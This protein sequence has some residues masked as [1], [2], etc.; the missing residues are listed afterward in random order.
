MEAVNNMNSGFG[1]DIIYSTASLLILAADK[2]LS[3]KQV[4]SGRPLLLGR[5]TKD[6]HPDVEIESKICGR[7]H[8]QLSCVNG[9]WVY[10]DLGSINGTYINGVLYKSEA[11]QAPAQVTLN[12]G[13][14]IRIDTTDLAHPDVDNGVWILFTID[15][16]R[17]GWF[18]KELK[19]NEEVTIGRVSDNVI[20]LNSAFITRHH[21]KVAWNG[22]EYILQ[23][24]GSRAGTWYNGTELTGPVALKN[25]DTFCICDRTFVFL[26]NKL[27]F[28]NYESAAS[29]PA[30]PAPVIGAQGQTDFDGT[31][32]ITGHAVQAAQAAQAAVQPTPAAAPVVQPTPAAAPVAQLQAAVQPTPAAAPVV[33][34][35]VAVQPTPAVVPVPT[36]V[37][38]PQPTPVAI[39]N[40]QPAVAPA[41]VQTAQPTTPVALHTA[42]TPNPQP[43]RPAAQ[44]QAVQ[45]QNT[46]AQPNPQ[47]VAQQPRQA[48]PVQQ[49]QPQQAGYPVQQAGYPVQQA[50]YPV[51]QAGYPVQQAGYP[52]QQAGYPVQQAGYPVQQAQQRNYL[53]QADIQSKKVKNTHGPGDVELLKNIRLNIEEG[54]LIALLGTAGAGKTTLMDILNASHPEG[55]TGRV[56][57][58]GQDLIAN[59]KRLKD[60]IGIVTQDTVFYPA[61]T[62]LEQINQSA[63]FYLYDYTR[64]ERK[65]KVEAL[66]NKF[67]MTP[68]MK[69][70]ISNCSGG[71]KRRVHIMMTMISDRRVFFMDEPDAGLDPGNKKNMFSILQNMAHDKDDPKTILVI[72]HDVSELDMFDQV[73]MLRKFNNVG[74]LSFAGSPQEAKAYYGIDEYQQMYEKINQDVDGSKYLMGGI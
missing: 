65:E 35:Q 52:V 63:E 54:S 55:V 41:V 53:I 56:T 17:G 71:E 51:Q 69:S 11:G 4:Q 68:K 42:P 70:Q 74:R 34:P 25:R 5:P 6:S 66:I 14:V 62:V 45:A 46:P 2:P 39:P 48:V 33:Q 64:K 16:K 72:I 19:F 26:N 60:T 30:A 47:A 61:L 12:S 1:Q 50:G 38:T 29:A 58:D 18:Q 36:V 13:D 20:S 27:F 7:R 21:A 31:V 67:G 28:S 57:M 73:I 59:A 32:A 37:P 10:T 3:I 15:Q 44:P 24:L 23:D 40:A 9:Q 43:L 8:A 22:K 49:A